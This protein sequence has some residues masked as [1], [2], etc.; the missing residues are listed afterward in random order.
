[1]SREEKMVAIILEYYPDAQA[2]YLFGSSGTEDVTE[3]ILIMPI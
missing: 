1:M 2:V 3:Y